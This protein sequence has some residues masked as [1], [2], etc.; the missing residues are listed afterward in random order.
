MNWGGGPTNA[1]KPD[2]PLRLRSGWWGRVY[3]AQFSAH[4]PDASDCTSFDKSE[5]KERVF[6]KIKMRTLSFVVVFCLFLFRIKPRELIA[7]KF[8]RVSII[9]KRVLVRWILEFIFTAFLQADF[10]YVLQFLLYFAVT[11]YYMYFCKMQ[12]YYTENLTR[13]YMNYFGIITLLFFLKKLS[14]NSTKRK[15]SFCFKNKEMKPK[16]ARYCAGIPLLKK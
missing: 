13:V 6:S 1:V 7:I 12:L 10:Y 11:L 3:W 5:G 8:Y 16:Y 9:K 4:S 15:K 14:I 2:H